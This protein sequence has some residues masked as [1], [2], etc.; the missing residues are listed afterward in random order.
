MT[1]QVAPPQRRNSGRSTA[2]QRAYERRSR[3][4]AL[5]GSE[6]VATRGRTTGTGRIRTRIPFVAT[7]IAL[8]G[9]GMAVTL[10]LTTRAT[11][12][13][14]QLSAA[15]AYNESLAQQRAVLERDV[16]S[17]NSAPALAVAAAGLG[18]IPSGEAAR[19]IVAPDGSVQLVG[20]PTPAQGA[21]PAP[22]NRPA[23]GEDV[24]VQ[25]PLSGSAGAE[26]PRP[27]SDVGEQP[28]PQETPQDVPADP[29]A[30][31]VNDEPGAAPVEA[32]PADA[33]PVTDPAATPVAGNPAPAPAEAPESAPVSEQPQPEAPRSLAP[34]LDDATQPGGGPR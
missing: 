5:T 21:P 33:A 13:S 18:M 30:A 10:L 20:E 27:L 23:E 25:T 2:A 12:D 24:R 31:A 17:G 14:Y 19:L 34:V 8:L 9:V 3:R 22:L 6:P 29:R 7:I 15:R 4:A 26:T 1:V 16:E 28:T 32:P 11:E